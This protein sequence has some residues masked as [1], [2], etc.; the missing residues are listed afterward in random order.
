MSTHVWLRIAD[1]AFLVAVV[2]LAVAVGWRSLNKSTEPNTL[3]LKWFI[4]AILV[5]IGVFLFRVSPLLF[6]LP[7]VVIGFIWVPSVGDLVTRI[8]TGGLDG[9]NTD[10]ELQP[11]YSMAEAKRR[12]SHPQEAIKA[13]REQLEK[14]PGDFPGV[15]LMASIQAEDLNDLAG[16][17]ATLENWIQGPAAT[18]Q[19]IA[20]ALTALADWQLEYAQDPEAARAALQRIVQTFPDTAIAHRA[21]QRLA[22]LPTL[23]HLLNSSTT[24]TMGLLA[25]EKDIGLRKDYTGPVAVTIDPAVLAESYVKQLEKHPADTA[26]REKLAVLYAEHFHRLDLAVEQ[27]EQLIN[28]P[29]E[30]P[31]HVAQWLNLLADLHIRFGNDEVAAEAALRRILDQFSTPAL[32]QPTMA[33]LATLHGE[34]KAGQ[35]NQLKTLGHYEKNLGLK[36]AGSKG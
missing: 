10:M 9:T 35:I 16:A 33:R 22:N 24:P 34:I 26:A 23:E 4:C 2:A 32:V 5:G 25:R 12:N 1:I 14:F 31:K 36:Q 3:L 17:Q 20:S 7:A 21:A 13:V 15:M 30:S 8:I 18:S 29:N 28:F 6:I 11:L 19:G 27:L